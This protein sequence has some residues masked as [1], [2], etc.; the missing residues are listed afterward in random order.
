MMGNTASDLG[1]SLSGWGDLNSRPLRP[2]ANARVR[3]PPLLL[4]LT[5]FAPSV[6]VR[7]YPLM[8]VAV[9]TQLFTHQSRACGGGG[10][11]SSRAAGLPG[12][13]RLGPWRF[14][15]SVSGG[16]IADVGPQVLG[17]DARPAQHPG[18]LPDPGRPDPQDE[19]E[20]PGWPLTPVGWRERRR[21]GPQPP[22]GE[23]GR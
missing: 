9:V 12:W 18:S 21:T 20:P 10:W 15:S 14:A 2:E 3:L 1:T 4:G 11:L 17:A 22:E 6:D 23:D 5:C 16:K 8:S 13:L 7:W 19:R